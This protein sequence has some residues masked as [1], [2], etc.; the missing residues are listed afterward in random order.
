MISNSAESIRLEVLRMQASLEFLYVMTVCPGSN[1][2]IRGKYPTSVVHTQK[3]CGAP[4]G[5]KG[6]GRSSPK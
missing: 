5:L 6:A 4:Y 3:G 1:C 2:Y